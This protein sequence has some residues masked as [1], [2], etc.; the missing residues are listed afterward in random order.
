MG[1]E[2]DRL[3]SMAVVV[4][5]AET[6][7]FADASRQLN[8]SAPSVTR[9]V[10]FIEE[11]IGAKLFLRS[12]RTV[13]LTEAGQHYVDDC[14]RILAKLEEAEAAARG[15][16]ARP[17]GTL[18]ITAPVLFGQIY[19][20]PI[21]TEYLA[22]YPWMQGR[23]L[24]LDRAVNLLEE[25]IDAGVRIGH[26]PDSGYNAIKVGTVRRVI[27]GAPSY[28]ERC[29]IPESP[30][31]LT[32]HTLIATTSSS[33]PVQWRLGH[34]P[35]SANSFSPRLYCNT[36]GAAIT[37]ATSGL[38]LVQALSYQVTEHRAEHALTIVLEDF[39]EEPLPIHVIHPEGRNASA[40]TRAFV[41]LAVDRLR[42]AGPFG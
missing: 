29:G 12:T 38:G 2:M 27:C 35:R 6:G 39:E 32:D 5:V 16:Y 28:F 34:S 17:S 10:A 1:A 11:T 8:M 23:A 37:A 21:L 20:M 36:V 41:D 4:K 15:S 19:I 13:K 26:L 33:A 14:R 25:G 31:D 30:K 40:K 9:A 42:A 18:T 24:L 22:M 7:S 3:K